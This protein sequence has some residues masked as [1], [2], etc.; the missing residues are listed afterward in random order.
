L[1]AWQDDPFGLFRSWAQARAQETPVR[2]RDGRLFVSEAR[3]D[4]VVTP[5][6]LRAPAFSIG[7]QQLALPILERSSAS[8]SEC[9]AAG[10]GP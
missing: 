5:I 8:R 4:Y 1:G 10:R 9:C 2:P 7:A 6:N 3:R